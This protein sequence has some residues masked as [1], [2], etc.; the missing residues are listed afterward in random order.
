MTRLLLCALLLALAIAPAAA[1]EPETAETVVLRNRIFDGQGFRDTLVP[2]QTERFAILADKD[3]ALSVRQTL[4]YY[5]PLS[6]QFYAAFERLD[7]PLEGVLRI[8][9]QGRVVAEVAAQP[10]VIVYPKGAAAG[11]AHLA[12]GEAAGQAASAYREEMSAY[13]RA[14]AAAQADRRRYESALKAGAI[15]RLKGEAVPPVAPPQ[16]VPDLPVRHVSDIHTGYPVR[17]PAGSYDIEAMVDGL[18]VEG[19]RRQLEAITPVTASAVTMD[20]VP[21]ERWTRVLPS[22]EA[23]DAIFAAPGATFYV[24]LNQSD[25]FDAAEWQSLTEPQ[26]AGVAGQPIWVRRGPALGRQLEARLDGDQW[27]VVP[28]RDYKVRQTQGA[29]LGYVIEPVKAGE[30]GDLSAYAV[31]VPPLAGGGLA[32]RV[33]DDTGAVVPGTER[34]IVVVEEGPSALLFLAATVPFLA[35]LGILGARRWRR[36]EGGVPS[37]LPTAPPARPA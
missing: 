3:N 37:G 19:S 31:K 32:L 18:V 34:R 28:L 35:G 6:R 4:E 8:T 33:I 20:V 30:T 23:G 29:Q 11:E 21:E 26:H 5:W 2:S 22:T 17:L 24:V 25:R 27:Q 7:E 16:P 13:N 14:L 10:Y 12:W 36:R 15:A 9:Q 1:I